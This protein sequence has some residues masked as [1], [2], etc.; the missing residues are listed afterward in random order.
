MKYDIAIIGG[1]IVGMSIAYEFARHKKSVVVIDRK[2]LTPQTS[3]A[4]VGI[5]PAVNL[6][7]AVE[8]FD[9]LRA[10]SDDLH[11]KWSHDF[12]EATG[13]DNELKPVG[14]LFVART[15]GE[16]ASLTGYK[17]SLQEDGIVHEVV[18]QERLDTLFPNLSRPLSSRQILKAVFVPGEKTI[19]NTRHMK[20]LSQVC[21][22]MGVR[23][24][25]G[26]MKLEFVSKNGRI[27]HLNVGEQKV[28][29]ENFC[30]A[31]GSWTQ[32]TLESLGVHISTVPIR[33][34]IAL[35]KI[36]KPRF[37]SVI[38]E[39][40]QYLVPRD[41]G[42]VLAGSTLEDVGFDNST[43]SD[44]VSRLVAFAND[45]E[46]EL[47]DSTFVTS[48][49]GLRPATNDGMPYIGKVTDLENTYIATGH[50]RS[51]IHMSPGTAM[52]MYKLINGL[53]LPIDISTF[54]PCRG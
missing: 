45:W 43:T 37:H 9:Q 10:I 49:A 53:E 3:W 13:I 15:P 39:G 27:N 32:K 35:F 48:W 5:L 30:F 16:I 23:C 46:Q 14:T 44:T 12:K 18:S 36:P 34:Q 31:G 1:G 52:I 17:T 24:L 29:A 11:V 21:E 6:E 42:H 50:F 40:S 19:R 33:G 47:N 28:E 54:S 2:T 51:G 26:E 25:H 41:D 22:S 7:K 20:A 38:Y 4:A 8:P